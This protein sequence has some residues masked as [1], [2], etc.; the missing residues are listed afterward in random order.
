MRSAKLGIYYFCE[1]KML[2]GIEQ[3]LRFA[4]EHD[5]KDVKSKHDEVLAEMKRR[6]KQDKIEVK[7]LI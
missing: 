6:K 4:L 2:H 7:K 5:I 3:G 1:W